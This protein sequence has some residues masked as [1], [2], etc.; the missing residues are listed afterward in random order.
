[1]ASPSSHADTSNGPLEGLSTKSYWGLMAALFLNAFND[2]VFRWLVVG[3]GVDL[4][5]AEDR[6]W[7]VALGSLLFLLPFIVFMGPA[8]YLNDRFGKNRVVLG[9]KVMEL[10]LMIGGSVAIALAAGLGD[11][12]D[13]TWYLV[14]PALLAIVFLMGT[15]SAL[16]GPAKYGVLPEIVRQDL[17]PKANGIMAALTFI[18]IVI[19]MMVGHMLGGLYQHDHFSGVVVAATTL[20]LIA[21]IGLFGAVLVRRL[22]PA[23]PD[24]PFPWNPFGAALT[25]LKL[26]FASVAMT[27]VALGIAFFWSLGVLTINTLEIY[28]EYTL[29]LSETGI[30]TLLA[31]L[32]LG[33]GLGNATAGWISAGRIEL[34]LV[35]FGALGIV[36]ASSLLWLLGESLTA[37]YIVLFV[38][39]LTSGMFEVPL[40]TYLQRKTELHLRGAVMAASNFLTFTGGVL[41]T[42]V[43]YLLAGDP[44]VIDDTSLGV[45]LGAEPLTIFLV[46]AGITLPVLLY[47]LWILPLESARFVARIG[48]SCRYRI[49]VV[50]AEHLPDR[51]GVLILCRSTRPLDLILLGVSAPRPPWR[52]YV[53]EPSDSWW[54]RQLGGMRAFDSDAG[55][56]SLREPLREGRVVGLALGDGTDP[57]DV[58]AA[59]ESVEVPKLAVQVD[60]VTDST[61]GGLLGG[62]LARLR[63]RVEVRFT[64]AIADDESDKRDA[65]RERQSSAHFD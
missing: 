43:F 13:F 7:L 42:G 30:G 56:E 1:M 31:I 49:T 65:L 63:P 47:M 29:E 25:N 32:T 24:K 20:I 11:D 34:G 4:L 60:Q 64:K 36:V 12:P 6:T 22:R 61:N 46:I 21:V 10:V 55:V 53:A 54:I 14:L 58:L 44:I 17:L 38:L 52:I 23:D 26:I 39:G 8:G 45:P 41:I 16:L 33:I 35:P 40:A 2:N 15:Q 62:W 28:G 37:A 48:L 57:Q 18:A 19:G 9:V 50:G 51:D 5:S 59:L 27:H 3:V